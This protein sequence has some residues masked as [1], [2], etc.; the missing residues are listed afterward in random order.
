MS[1]AAALNEPNAAL[2]EYGALRRVMVCPAQAGYA[3]Q[4]RLDAL[5]QGEEFLGRPD[6]DEARREYDRFAEVLTA[7]LTTR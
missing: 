7:A 1:L 3:S 6:F 5:W 2:N 4:A